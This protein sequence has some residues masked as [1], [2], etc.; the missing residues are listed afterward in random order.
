[1][2]ISVA[3]IAWRGGK[4]LLARRMP[5]GTNSRR[6]EFPGG[7]AEEGESPADSLTREFQEELG[8]TVEVADRLA[9][10]RFSHRGVDYRLVAYR[11]IL[12]EG[13]FTLR[14]HEAVEWFSFDEV[15]R[16]SLVPSDRQI[17]PQ[18]RAALSANE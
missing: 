14:E 11:I 3:G 17:L 5:G 13:E 12:H 9:E 4:L 15:E 8:V 7:K 18:L 10:G 6:W 16:L 2:R 1:L